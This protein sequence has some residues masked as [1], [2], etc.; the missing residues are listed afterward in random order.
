MMGTYRF[1]L[2]GRWMWLWGVMFALALMGHRGPGMNAPWLQV[3]PNAAPP[4]AAGGGNPGTEEGT[5]VQMVRERVVL[6]LSPDGSKATVQG[7]YIMRNQGEGE[8]TLAVHYPLRS[9]FDQCEGEEIEGLRVWVNDRPVSTRRVEGRPIP[10]HCDAPSPWAAFEAT[11]PP[12]EEVTLRVTYQQATWG[13]SPYR[14]LTYI[15]E[16]GAGWRGRIEEA[17]IRVRLPYTATEETIPLGKSFWGYG[18][19]TTPGARL[20]GQEVVWHF[21]DLEPTREHNIFLLFLQPDYWQE[22]QRRRRA[23]QDNPQDGEAWGFLGLAIK[24]AL[25]LPGPGYPMRFD[26]PGAQSL[27]QEALQA[28]AKAV[29]LKPQDPDWHFGYGQLLAVAASHAQD[30]A[31]RAAW[32]ERA[33]QEFRQTLA[34]KP[35]HE[36]TLEFYN[37]M[38]WLLEGWMKKRGEVFV[39][40]GLT[41]TPTLPRPTA[42][43]TQPFPTG[44]AT[45]PPASPG[46]VL[47]QISPTPARPGQTATSLPATPSPAGPAGAEGAWLVTGGTVLLLCL[48][49]VGVILAGSL[50]LTLRKRG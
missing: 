17:E 48:C 7:V 13:Y 35:G 41:A 49:L 11:F 45:L 8:E 29:T 12:G 21:R 42:P 27:L 44:T 33:V 25:L 38:S 30:P 1:P 14:V 20:E 9:L 18:R 5:Q 40:P 4:E 3:W 47:P 34:L 22:I 23:V 15:L 2:R 28:Y 10:A 24:K 36:K 37:E 43:P 50:Y 6:T 32:L 19:G 46:P 26:D 31:Q 39:Y 16:T